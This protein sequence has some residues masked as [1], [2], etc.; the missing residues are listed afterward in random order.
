MELKSNGLNRILRVVL[1]KT[2]IKKTVDTPAPT[3]AS[4]NATSTAPIPVHIKHIKK[5]YAPKTI[6]ELTRSLI[7]NDTNAKITTRINNKISIDKI[8]HHSPMDQLQNYNPPQL[9]HE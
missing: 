2:A 4:V 1:N 3:T 6:T 7:H 5:L 8:I 9:M